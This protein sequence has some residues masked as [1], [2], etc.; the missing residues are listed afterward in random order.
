MKIGR[1]PV[2]DNKVANPSYMPILKSIA[3]AIAE[4]LMGNTSFCVAFLIQGHAHFS[5]GCEFMTGLGQWL[6]W[7]EAPLMLRGQCCRFRNTKGAP[8]I[9]GIA[10]LTQVHS[11]PTFPLGV[12]FMAG[13]GIPK[14][15][16]EF[17]VAS[18]SHCVNIEGESP[19]FEE[20]P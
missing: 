16:T 10:S 7:Q 6:N 19:N 14:L 5:S 15:C 18:F 1:A 4:I 17:E 13:F 12:V 3:S 9:Y 2:A 11:T 8:Q 20:L